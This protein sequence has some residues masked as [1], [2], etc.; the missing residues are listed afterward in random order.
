MAKVAAGRIARMATMA[1]SEH[2]NMCS[3]SIKDVTACRL[4]PGL[5]THLVTSDWTD[6]GT[7]DNITGMHMHSQCV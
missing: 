5:S 6:M 3:C 2:Q 7:G 4:Q 1:R